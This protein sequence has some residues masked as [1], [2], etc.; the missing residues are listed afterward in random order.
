MR[1][2]DEGLTTCR[3]GRMIQTAFR[4]IREKY[5]RKKHRGSRLNKRPKMNGFL[6]CLL[7]CDDRKVA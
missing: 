3:V 2:E 7:C 4:E 5:I 1:G 6:L